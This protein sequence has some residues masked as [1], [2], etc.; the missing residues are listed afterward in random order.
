MLA[1]ALLKEVFA[2]HLNDVSLPPGIEV[3]DPFRSENSAQVHDLVTQFHRK[4]YADNKPRI[5]MLG[6]NP[7]RFG[8]GIT[9]IC[10]TDT[11]RCESEL[12]LPVKGIRTHEPSSDFFYRAVRAAGGPE[13]FYSRVYV[14]ALCPLGFTRTGPKGTPVNLNYY[15]DSELQ[16]AITPVVTSWINKL[17]A[18]GLRTDVMACIGTGKNLAFLKK[19]ND[20]H[21][22]FQ[23]IIPLEHPRFVM[24]YRFK[25]LEEY[26]AKYAEASLG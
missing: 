24:Q 22:F 20:R 4:F 1:T 16:E 15:D 9:G 26:A 3:L 5:L 17:I 11:K 18:T 21:G 19:L 25:R 12:G 14:Q 7:G 23:R 2:F 10:F 13:A 6:I 8:A